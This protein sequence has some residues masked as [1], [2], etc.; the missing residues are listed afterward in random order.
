MPI[1]VNGVDIVDDSES[2]SQSYTDESALV[3]ERLW[4][5]DCGTSGVYRPQETYTMQMKQHNRAYVSTD[6]I[7]LS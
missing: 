2:S 3:S 1:N 7:G 5:Y 4:G 6:S